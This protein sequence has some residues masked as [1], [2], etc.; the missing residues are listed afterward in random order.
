MTPEL[1]SL[2]ASANCHPTVPATVG[3]S[4]PAQPLP[5]VPSH[6]CF[7]FLCNCCLGSANPDLLLFSSLIYCNSHLLV[8]R[9]QPVKLKVFSPHIPGSPGGVFLAPDH[10]LQTISLLPTTLLMPF[11]STTRSHL[12]SL[13][14]LFIEHLGSLSPHPKSGSF[15]MIFTSCLFIP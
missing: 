2:Y 12:P 11:A 10:H 6:T 5:A 8:I 14:L 13:S 7:L 9:G 15:L 3:V 1:S 4:E